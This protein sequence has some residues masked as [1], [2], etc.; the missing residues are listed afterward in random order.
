MTPKFQPGEAVRI[1]ERNQPGH[2]RTPQYV[3]G[4]S[5]I[6]ERIVGSFPNPET[7]AYGQTGL[8]YKMLYRV[9]FKQSDLWADYDGKP[10]D[11][12]EL[13]I[14]EHWLEPV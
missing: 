1:I 7:L 14:Y 5:G 13:E 6:V 3:R 10:E 12:L 8:P 4:K 9:H 11:T 2:V